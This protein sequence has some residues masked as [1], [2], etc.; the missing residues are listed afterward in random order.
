MEDKYIPVPCQFY[1]RLESLAVKNIKS[2]IVFI[3]DKTEK[4]I[5]SFIVDFK[6]K[7]KE[8][9]IILSNK[10]EIRLDKIVSVNGMS[11]NDHGCGL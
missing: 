4:S 1:D 5:E 3:E 6:T 10:E 2:V 7:D 11:P 8:E 9:F